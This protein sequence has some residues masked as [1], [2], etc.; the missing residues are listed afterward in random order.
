MSENIKYKIVDKKTTEELP[1]FD[2]TY[3][4]PDTNVSLIKQQIKE[5]LLKKYKVN[6][7][8]EHIK[9]KSKSYKSNAQHI[10]DI[11]ISNVFKNPTSKDNVITFEIV[12]NDENNIP[13]ISEIRTSREKTYTDING[14][15][16]TYS[17]EKDE[18]ENP[19]GNGIIKYISGDNMGNEYIG[20]FNENYLPNGHG[21]MV[22]RNQLDPILKYSGTFSNGIIQPTHV[23][24]I[25]K[26]NNQNN[27]GEYVGEVKNEFRI[28]PHGRGKMI[29]VNLDEFIGEFVLGRY[30]YG[31]MY[32]KN[33]QI[34]SYRGPWKHNKPNAYG[35]TAGQ[36]IIV[37]SKDNIYEGDVVDGVY[38]G[39]GTMKYN[40]GSNRRFY[41]GWWSNGQP[42]DGEMTYKDGRPPYQ[43]DWENGE[44][45]PQPI[46]QE[47]Q[48]M[49]IQTGTPQGSPDRSRRTDQPPKLSRKKGGRTVTRKYRNQKKRRTTIGNKKSKIKI[50]K[51]NRSRKH[52]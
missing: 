30:E 33:G 17:G 44:P 24:I 8:P 45:I 4:E 49:N 7:N 10:P 40:D 3:Y 2:D 26:P 12:N 1:P 32:Y 47:P 28:R 11:E 37:D 39:Y 31:S 38:E 51:V 43:G 18:Y 36:G 22:I 16:F 6:I 5:Y 19:Y 20:M 48:P 9:L 25:Y 13:N 15:R 52:S 50:K 41:D 46:P 14:N 23:S 34:K 42:K 21:T 29:L 35:R 27:Y